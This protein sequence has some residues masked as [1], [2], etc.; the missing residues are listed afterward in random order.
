MLKKVRVV[1]AAV[2]FS[3]VCLL[4]ADFTGALHGWL[5]WVA[6]V[7]LVPAVL[8]GNFVI[9]AAIVVFT[10]LFGRIYCSVICPLGIYQDVVSHLAARRKKYRYA[11]AGAKWILRIALLVVFVA[12][13]MC[14]LTPIASIIE[15]YSAFGR[16]AETIL[17]PL[18][19]L[20]NNLLALGAEKVDSYAFYS[21]D[22]WVKSLA[23]LGVAVVTAVVVGILAWRGGR[24]YCNTICPVGTFL[25]LFSKFALFRIRINK[26][27][28]N[29]CHLCEKSCKAQCINSKEQKIDY[30][31]CVACMDCIGA[32][33]QHAISFTAKNIKVA[34]EATKATAD[35]PD[36]AR[37]AFIGAGIMLAATQLAKAEEKTTDG[38]FAEIA[39]RKIPERNTPIIPAGAKARGHF[40]KHCTA[41]QLCVSKC[42]NGVLRPSTN[43]ETFMQP[44]MSFENGFCRPECTACSDVCPTGAIRLADGLEKSQIQIGHAVWVRSNCLNINSDVQC[45]NC[46]RKCPSQAITMVPIDPTN[47]ESKKIPSV[48]EERCIGCGACEHL[49][50]ARPFS[51]IYVEGHER[52]KML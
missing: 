8:A 46:S 25:G 38:G 35:Q 9:A 10:L 31:R 21:T 27:K 49:C 37:R 39:E 40:S 45:D 22:V 50:P 17:A 1:A 42:P 51:A 18:Y 33:R 14:R 32:C 7:Q 47:P 48:M 34:P 36:T 20:G 26:N 3:L 11:F 43:L 4:F 2:M 15:P 24:T 6:K 12:L 5:G 19:R 30:S 16:M 13:I 29:G 23:T 52:H 28:C 44:E 41:C